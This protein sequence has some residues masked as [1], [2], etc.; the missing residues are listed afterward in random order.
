MNCFRDIGNPEQRR[1]ALLG[2]GLKSWE[3]VQR[4]LLRFDRFPPLLNGV[5]VWRMGRQLDAVK[6]CGLLGEE[7]YCDASGGGVCRAD[8]DRRDV[9]GLVSWGGPGGRRRPT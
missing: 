7:G 6:P 9:L 4:S 1:R 5:I 2:Q 3:G 8:V